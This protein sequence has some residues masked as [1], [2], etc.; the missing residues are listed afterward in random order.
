MNIE[1]GELFTS[2]IVSKSSLVKIKQRQNVNNLQLLTIVACKGNQNNKE[3]TNTL[4]F[5]LQKGIWRLIKC[6]YS[7]WVF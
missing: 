1:T 3:F 2:R 7:P 4:N 6:L 5:K